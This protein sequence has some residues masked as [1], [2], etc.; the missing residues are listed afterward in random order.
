MK[1]YESGFLAGP[2]GFEPL[3][4]GFLPLFASGGR[5]LNPCWATGPF[6]KQGARL[7]FKLAAIY[8]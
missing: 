6:L 1:Q 2:R 4:F 8:S 3:V 7:D 5:R